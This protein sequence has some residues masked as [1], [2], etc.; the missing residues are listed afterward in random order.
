MELQSLRYAEM[1][2]AMGFNELVETYQAYLGTHEPAARDSAAIRIREFLGMSPGE[3]I[4]VSSVPRIIL[5]SADFSLEITTTVLWL[6]RRGVDIRCIQ[7]TPYK[8]DGTI[9]LDLH[10]VIPL[11]EA[12]DYQIRLRKKEEEARFSGSG[13]REL[14]LKVLLRHGV[15]KPG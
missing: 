13:R 7:V 1:V 11:A 5:I 14:T 6:I 4:S 8:A 15:L 10:Q 12:A 9:L 3:D 2:S